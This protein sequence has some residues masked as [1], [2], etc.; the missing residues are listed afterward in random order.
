M[1]IT[2]KEYLENLFNQKW[3]PIFG[4]YFSIEECESTSRCTAVISNARHFLGIVFNSSHPRFFPTLD[5]IKAEIGHVPKGIRSEK[6]IGPDKIDLKVLFG[7]GDEEIH[8]ARDFHDQI[9]DLTI[10]LS[11]AAANAHDIELRANYIISSFECQFQNDF[12]RYKM[13]KHIHPHLYN[14]QAL[15]IMAISK[16]YLAWRA[17][18][19]R[20]IGYM[21]AWQVTYSNKWQNNLSKAECLLNIAKDISIE[22]LKRIAEYKALPLSTRRYREDKFECRLQAREYIKNNENPQIKLAITEL[23]KVEPGKRYGD[24]TI[25]RWIAPLFPAQSRKPGRPKIR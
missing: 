16:A 11:I 17:L 6:S 21:D 1:D 5:E 12:F 7:F 23:Q 24:K 22:E 4:E 14:Y 25:R 9:T 10:P 19:T 18:L 8:A 20:R 2:E 3:C 13:M 15:A